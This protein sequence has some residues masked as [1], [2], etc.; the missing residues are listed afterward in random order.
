M[1]I[2]RMD[3][4][5]V[6]VEDLTAATDFFV[7]L[8]LQVIGDGSAEGDWVG[9]IIGLEDVRARIVM[10]KTPDG[11]SRIELAS[12]DTPPSPA[13]EAGEASN[14]PGIRHLCFNVDDIEATVDRLRGHG[15]EF[16]GT[17]ERYK[18]TYL[19]CYVRGPQGI[20]VELAQDLS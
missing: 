8:G 18:D 9:R 17:I 19:L 12:F 16:V 14:V 6:I 13:G 10:L 20:I 11:K 2:N 3:H 4:V 7:E 1:S 15:A 5:G